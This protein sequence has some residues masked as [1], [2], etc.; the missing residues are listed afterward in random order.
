MQGM[1]QVNSN[2]PPQPFPSW[3]WLDPT[4]EDV[5]RASEW[6]GADIVDRVMDV[7]ASYD[8]RHYLSHGI[9]PR[10][11]TVLVSPWMARHGHMLLYRNSPWTAIEALRANGIGV[12]TGMDGLRDAQPDTHHNPP[13]H[14]TDLIVV[15]DGR[16]YDRH[17][18]EQP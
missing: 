11:R 8:E 12:L 3:P 15:V 9:T 7:S 17:I 13:W 1:G 18:M 2:H 16:V 6:T 14:A 4:T 10:L 5:Q